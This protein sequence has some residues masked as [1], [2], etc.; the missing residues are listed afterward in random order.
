ML[1]D[2]LCNTIIVASGICAVPLLSLRHRLYPTLHVTTF[3]FWHYYALCLALS[4]WLPLL[5][6]QKPMLACCSALAIGVCCALCFILLWFGMMFCVSICVSLFVLCLISFHS[7]FDF[8]SYT[9]CCVFAF[10]QCYSYCCYRCCCCVCFCFLLLLYL[11]YLL[12][13][14]LLLLHLRRFCTMSVVDVLYFPQSRCAFSHLY[15]YYIL[16]RSLHS[17]IRR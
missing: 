9:L 5:P 1:L 6:R 3:C 8:C 17:V 15:S 4:L 13:L 7:F 10:A 16:A 14:L 2:S 11:L 12:L